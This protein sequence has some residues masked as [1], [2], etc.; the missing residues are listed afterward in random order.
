MMQCW[1][2][3]PTERPS[4]AYL[5]DHLNDLNNQQSLYVEFITNE[6]LPPPGS[7]NSSKTERIE[8]EK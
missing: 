4:F 1:A 6:Q 7:L 3:N 5:C 8:R 2:E